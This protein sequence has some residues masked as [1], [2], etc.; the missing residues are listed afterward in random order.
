MEKMKEE[1]QTIEIESVDEEDAP[2]P[3]QEDEAEPS[4]A[5]RGPRPRWASLA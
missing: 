3:P 1:M 5:A 4:E 2:A